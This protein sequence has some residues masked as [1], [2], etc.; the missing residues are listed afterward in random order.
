MAQGPCWCNG[1]EMLSTTVRYTEELNLKISVLPLLVMSPRR[2]LAP[3]RGGWEY[4]SYF[5]EK[6][7]LCHPPSGP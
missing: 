7:N 3:H 4:L 6:L 5:P 2:I 1:L